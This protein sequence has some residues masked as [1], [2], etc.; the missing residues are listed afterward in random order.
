MVQRSLTNTLL[1][2][3]AKSQTYWHGFAKPSRFHLVQT[4]THAERDACGGMLPWLRMLLWD[5]WDNS[6][7][8]NKER[9]GGGFIAGV[10][11]TGADTRGLDSGDAM[12][13]RAWEKD[14]LGKLIGE[15]RAIGWR[16][17]ATG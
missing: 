10:G 5:E 11:L 13:R 4:E 1:H 14:M 3:S 6:R 7:K 9:F 12:P 17:Q 2:G 16:V 8:Q 15:S